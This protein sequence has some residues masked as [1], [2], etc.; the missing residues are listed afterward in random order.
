MKE[1]IINPNLILEETKTIKFFLVL[2]YIFFFA[3]DFYYYYLMP[4]YTKEGEIGAPNEG[5]GLFFHL[6]VLLLLP[7]ALYFIK[8]G[9]PYIVKYIY[10]FSYAAIETV[11]SL[12]IY[13]GS[14][15]PFGSGNIVELLFVFFSP[16]FVNKKY[17]WTASICMIGKYIIIGGILQTSTVVIAIIVFCI[18]SVIAFFLL[19]RF[20]SYINALTSVHLELRQNEKLAVIGQMAAGIGHEIRNPLSSLKGFTQLQQES[21]PNTNDFYPIMIKEIDRINSIV[22]D[23]MYLGK[24]KEINFS[25]ASIEKIIEYTLSI[26]QQQAEKMGVSVETTMAGPLPPIDCDRKQLKQVLIN[27]IKNAIESMPSGGKIKIKVKVVDLNKMNISIQDEGS[28]IDDKSILNLGEPFFTTKKDGTGLGLMVTK[29]IIGDH[30][31][32]LKIESKLGHGT[33]VIVT[34]PISQI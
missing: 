5:F 8:K 1:T 9:N 20:T 22:N 24:P 4:S 21:Y 18:L 26:T 13:L 30:K 23:L 33:K 32:D 11:N 2:F 3:Y 6:A 27:L 29:Q 12:V 19:T 10:L 16:I 34:L 15:K 25:K 31:G 14:D 17:F 7:V 28:G